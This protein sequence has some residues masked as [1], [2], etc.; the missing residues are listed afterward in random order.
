LSSHPAFTT[1]EAAA[2]ADI[3]LECTGYVQILLEVVGT[4]NVSIQG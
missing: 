1:P 3:T 2:E 4:Q